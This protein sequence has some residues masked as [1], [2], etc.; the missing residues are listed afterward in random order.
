MSA[1]NNVPPKLVQLSSLCW[2]P[3]SDATRACHSKPKQGLFGMLRFVLS[4]TLGN[5]QTKTFSGPPLSRA[6]LATCFQANRHLTYYQRVPRRWGLLFVR[7]GCQLQGI[8]KETTPT[9]E[10][11]KMFTCAKISSSIQPVHSCAWA[12]CQ[13]L[14]WARDSHGC[15]PPHLVQRSCPK[16]HPLQCDAGGSAI[17]IRLAVQSGR[18]GSQQVSGHG[19]TVH[20]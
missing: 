16:A 20:L 6:S 15:V 2:P 11:C 4:N 10:F 18:H 13:L 1:K 8:T 14:H 9:A 7:A 3:C 19:T 12:V 17:S 5:L